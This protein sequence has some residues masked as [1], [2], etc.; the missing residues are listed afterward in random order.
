MDQVR[1][2][3]KAHFVDSRLGSV[4]RR[5][6]FVAAAADAE[7]LQ[8]LGLVEVIGTIEPEEPRAA[9]KQS[10]KVSGDA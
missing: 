6:E 5:S 10:K 8:E 3:A 7:R 4:T 9:K 1:L 2:R